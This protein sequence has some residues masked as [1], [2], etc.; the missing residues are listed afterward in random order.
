MKITTNNAT[1]D[2]QSRYLFEQE[3]I[4]QRDNRNIDEVMKMYLTDLKNEIMELIK[5]KARIKLFCLKTK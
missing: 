4:I 3:K 2:N 1:I 5:A